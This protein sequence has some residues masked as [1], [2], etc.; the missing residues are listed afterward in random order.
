MAKIYLDYYR[1]LSLNRHFLEPKISKNVTKK[2]LHYTY[3]HSGY[4]KDQSIINKIGKILTLSA[5]IFLILLSLGSLLVSKSFR[6]LFKHTWQSCKEGTEL[7]ISHLY[8]AKETV[9]FADLRKLEKKADIFGDI[10][11]KEIEEI[12]FNEKKKEKNE[13]QK[14]DLPI[15]EKQRIDLPNQL[16][17]FF[18]GELKDIANWHAQKEQDL[19]I[20]EESKIPVEP[21]L[22]NFAILSLEMKKKLIEGMNSE[23]ILAF[24]KSNIENAKFIFD[25]FP[26]KVLLAHAFNLWKANPD[27]IL[28]KDVKKSNWNKIKN[29]LDSYVLLMNQFPNEAVQIYEQLLISKKNHELSYLISGLMKFFIINKEAAIPLLNIALNRPIPKYDLPVF[30]FNFAKINLEQA[31]VIAESIDEQNIKRIAKYLLALFVASS[32]ANKAGDIINSLKM[33][34]MDYLNVFS[35]IDDYDKKFYLNLVKLPENLFLDKLMECGNS[36]SKKNLIKAYIETQQYKKALELLT[37]PQIFNDESF[38]GLLI[39]AYLKMAEEKKSPQIAINFLKEIIK[40]RQKEDSKFSQNLYEIGT[41]FYQFSPKKTDK[42]FDIAKRVKYEKDRPYKPNEEL[43]KKAWESS[44]IEEAEAY[45]QIKPEEALKILNTIQKR[46]D[47]KVNVLIK[48]AKKYQ[49]KHP[50]IL[51]LLDEIYLLSNEIPGEEEFPYGNELKMK[52]LVKIAK[53]YAYHNCPD[54]NKQ[55]YENAKAEMEKLKREKHFS[56]LVLIPQLAQIAFL[57]D[58]N[59][60]IN[61]INENLNPVCRY[62]TYVNISKYLN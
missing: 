55:I 22:E 56:D 7:E 21:K 6:H 11:Q 51:K 8:L 31:F 54:K 34:K 60:A 19:K 33:E 9:Q 10:I 27:L 29:K 30:A 50:Q 58:P 48:V 4:L 61:I 59:E 40:T 5:E 39:D 46:S 62:N 28:E 18:N 1:D 49:K 13:E 43:D 17:D 36:K 41:A 3:I 24:S 15:K 32:D 26:R 57:V 37:H 38:F 35:F 16:I 52:K 14:I 23:E 53:L 45:V 42:I 47:D 44:L 12:S 2:K 20:D 25:Y